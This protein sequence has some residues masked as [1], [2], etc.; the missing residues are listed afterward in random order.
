MSLFALPY[1]LLLTVAENLPKTDLY[2]L[3]RTSRCLANLL[4][5]LLHTLGARESS[6]H[7]PLCWAAEHEEIELVRILLAK[8]ATMAPTTGSSAKEQ[9][10]ALH[11]A[12]KSG[13]KAIID[14]FLENGADINAATESNGETALLWAIREGSSAVVQLLLEHGASV[15]DDKPVS[16]LLPEAISGGHQNIAKLLIEREV[17]V[18]KYGVGG[19]LPLHLAAV[20]GDEATVALLLEKG[21]EV[22]AF[23]RTQFQGTALHFAA[24]GGH[25]AI[26]GF[27]LEKGA[28]IEA[29]ALDTQ[30]TPFH[31]AALLGQV[32]AL[33]FLLEK[34][35]NIGARCEDNSTAL[36]LAASG[37]EQDCRLIGIKLL[38][39]K[40]ADVNAQ[41]K[42]GDTPLREPVF[43]GYRK[44]VTA[45]VA[46]GG[47]DVSL[48]D[49]YG[50]SILD[51]AEKRR[52]FKM[53]R[54]LI[55]HGVKGSRRRVIRSLKSHGR[56]LYYMGKGRKYMESTMST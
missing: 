26:M 45:L 21:A 52:D 13:S 40:G 8:G 50:D 10:T 1:E 51:E 49:I 29:R 53:A 30:A 3:I 25:L 33:E 22:D 46:Q 34:G 39:A 55:R 28:D 7:T 2:A 5:P 43:R 18:N 37:E 12:A 24:G 14:I 17:D 23:D 9:A 15:N 56:I 54:L 31:I 42:Y 47:A 4:I 35:A 41:N 38:V 27:L 44:I 16:A 19:K 36:H 48:K 11:W 32:A 20:N 6:G